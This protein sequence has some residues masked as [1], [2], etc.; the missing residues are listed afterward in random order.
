MARGKWPL[1]VMLMRLWVK[2]LLS[3]QPVGQ[4]GSSER[5]VV[6]QTER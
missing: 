3:L 5:F 4:M 1:G 2:T 6:R